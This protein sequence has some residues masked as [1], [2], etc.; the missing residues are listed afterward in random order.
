M[1]KDENGHEIDDR[2]R[3]ALLASVLLDEVALDDVLDD[4]TVD[5]VVML[6]AAV[7]L[8]ILGFI[9]RRIKQTFVLPSIAS[10]V[11][12][13]SGGCSIT[14]NVLRCVPKNL[15][16]LPSILIKPTKGR[17]DKEVEG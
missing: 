3:L 5:V 9:L 2:S 1:A 14:K 4:A 6:V 7:E 15:L 12:S 17:G 10:K 8:A 13:A 16:P 11:T